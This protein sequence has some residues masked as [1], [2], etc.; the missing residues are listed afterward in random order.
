MNWD[1]LQLDILAAPPEAGELVFLGRR[2]EEFEWSLVGADG[3]TP[4]TDAEGPALDAWI[5]YAGGWPIEQDKVK[6]FFDDLRA[7]MES[8]VGGADRCRWSLDDPWPHG[9]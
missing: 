3:Q 9:H 5:Y 8:M 4:H 1:Q 7:E 2:G 6:P